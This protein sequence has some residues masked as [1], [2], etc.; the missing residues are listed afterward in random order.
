MAVRDLDL[1]LVAAL[2]ITEDPDLDRVAAAATV[3]QGQDLAAAAGNS[4]T[5]AAH[6]HRKPCHL[7][8]ANNMDQCQRAAMA[9]ALNT[10]AHHQAQ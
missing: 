8:A 6:R 3:D 1:D 10:E 5:V 9:M 7:L 4:S 2:V